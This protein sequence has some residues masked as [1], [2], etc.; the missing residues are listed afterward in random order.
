MGFFDLKVKCS[1]CDKEAGLNRYQIA[2]KGW[3][4]KDCFKK[5][6]FNLATPIK[7]MTVEDIINVLDKN[8]ENKRNFE[9]FNATKIIGNF[10]IDDNSKKWIINNKGLFSKNVVPKIFNYSDIVDFELL[11]DGESIAK[12]GLGRAVV[13]G[14]LFGGIGAVVG[15]IT[16]KKKSKPGCNSLK[17]KITLND[18]NNSSVYVNFITT[19]VKKNSFI[20]KTEFD[21]AQK[22]LSTLQVITNDATEN[23]KESSTGSDAD[24]IR[25]FKK[26][27]DEG[28]ITK[29]EFE[30]KKKQLLGL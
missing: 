16:G 4:C 8:D 1:I 18:I 28:I 7:K 10:E 30:A 3:I 22:C 6:G 17:I 15:G 20:Y 12:G 23:I 2:N 26:L 9:Q 13:G 19:S 21:L 27:L 25:K 5:A 29:E 11:E 24:E 14:V